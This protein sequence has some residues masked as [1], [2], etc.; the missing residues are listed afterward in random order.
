MRNG[1]PEDT[2]RQEYLCS[3]KEARLDIVDSRL[4]CGCLYETKADEENGDEDS[5]VI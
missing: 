5:S 4:Q 3:A 1:L 2:R